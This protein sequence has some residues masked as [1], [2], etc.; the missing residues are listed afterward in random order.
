NASRASCSSTPSISYSTAPGLISDTQY[1]GLP[2]PLP[3]RTSAGFCEIGL[4]GKMRIQMRPPRL[5]ARDIARRAASIWRAVRRPRVV[6]FSP[7]SPKLTLL[8]RVAIPRLRPFCSLRYLR[9]AGCSILRSWLAGTRGSPRR[10]RLL[11]LA[12]G[13]GAIR[14]ARQRGRGSGRFRGRPASQ[15]RGHGGGGLFVFLQY[16]ALEHPDLEADDAV[17]GHRGRDAV[18][19]IR[20]QRMQRH[21]AFPVPLV[22]RDLDTVQPSGGRDLDA[23]GAEPHRIGDGALHRAAKHDALLQLLCDRV[24]DQLR[25]G[26]GLAH[27]LDVD[28]HRHTQHLLQLNLERFDVLALLAN[29]HTRTRAVNRDA[30]VL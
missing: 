17:A 11:R 21:A 24:G 29:H 10:A 9:L 18:I 8:P 23:L 4:S 30:G 27:F 2:L 5:M 3:M 15:R 25:V 6:A 22:A 16:L 19:D 7:Y 12:R 26:L 1:S 14:R 20:A 28:V 13:R